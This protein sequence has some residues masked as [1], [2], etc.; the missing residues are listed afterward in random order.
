MGKNNGYFIFRSKIS[1]EFINNKKLLILKMA[2]N[3]NKIAK[4]DENVIYDMGNI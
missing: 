4:Y 2:P 3:Y 1:A